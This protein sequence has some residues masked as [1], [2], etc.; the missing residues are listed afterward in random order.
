MKFLK[1]NTR[2]A[3]ESYNSAFQCAA[4]KELRLLCLQEVAWCRMVQLDFSD[5]AYRF[6]E[7]RFVYLTE[8]FLSFPKSCSLYRYRQ[9]CSFSKAFYAYLTAICQGSQGNYTNLESFR[10]EIDQLTRSSSRKVSHLGFYTEK[11]LK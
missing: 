7:L 8:K 5:S 1:A 11:N 6:N 4:Q 3:I 2:N 10:K 9:I